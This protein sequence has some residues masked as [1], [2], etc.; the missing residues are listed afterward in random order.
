[1]LIE[2]RFELCTSLCPIPLVFLRSPSPDEEALP[3]IEDSDSDSSFVI[4]DMDDEDEIAEH[5]RYG[6]CPK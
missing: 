2:G 3:N 5:D 1:M 4:D 6:V